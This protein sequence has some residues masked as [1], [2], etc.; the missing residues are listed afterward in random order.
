MSPAEAPATTDTATWSTARLLLVDVDAQLAMAG[1][2]I[3]P[4]TV[5]TLELVVAAGHTI[6]LSTDR[7]LSGLLRLAGR[8]GVREGYAICSH[9]ALTVR[10]DAGMPG[11]YELLDAVVFDLDALILQLEDLQ[12]LPETLIAAEDP[13]TGWRVSRQ[14]A[15]ALLHGV[16]EQVPLA[17]LRGEVTSQARLHAPGIREYADVLAQATG[18]N[19]I[20]TGPDSCDV[21]AP[22]TSPDTAREAIHARLGRP[23]HTTVVH[24]NLHDS[25]TALVPP[26]ALRPGLSPL[27]AQLTAAVTS[28]VPKATDTTSGADR[29]D[30]AGPEPATVVRVWHGDG[31]D[32][33]G[34]EI[35]IRRRHG[36]VRHAPVPAGR[37]ATMLDIQHA[38]LD[39]DLRYPRGIEGR[40]RPWWRT[41]PTIVDD[42]GRPAGFELP[43][44]HT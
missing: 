43:L 7:S 30:V 8:F 20:L 3:S 12:L 25:L 6:L 19:V 40:R 21:T 36:W 4:E 41:A 33:A 32:L 34:A 11:G 9:G 27:A 26:A 17:R 38:A 18:L 39:A 5:Q 14:P 22:A 15:T 35:W 37:G 23:L 42:A 1:R 13:G 44:T 29:S 2:R 28:A 16:Q 31:V 24:D 10:L